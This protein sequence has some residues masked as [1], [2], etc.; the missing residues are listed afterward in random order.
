LHL[1]EHQL[2]FVVG[3]E[4]W[5]LVHEARIEKRLHLELLIQLFLQLHVHI[6]QL[7]EAI[8]HLHMLKI[9]WRCTLQRMRT[10]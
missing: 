8:Q 4:A 3:S 7:L 1:H 9:L 2:P 10:Y 6:E 5:V